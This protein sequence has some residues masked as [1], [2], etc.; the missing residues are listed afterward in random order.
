MPPLSPLSPSSQARRE[1]K[2]KAKHANTVYLLTMNKQ[3]TKEEIGDMKARKMTLTDLPVDLLEVIFKEEFRKLLKVSLRKWIYEQADRIDMKWLCANTSMHAI[4]I[5]KAKSRKN[6]DEL[7]W[8]RLSANPSAIDILSENEDRINWDEFSSNTSPDTITLFKRNMKKLNFA[9]LSGNPS[10]IYVLARNTYNVV[11][12]Y[13]GVKAAPIGITKNKDIDWMKVAKNPNGVELILT[14]KDD[15]EWDYWE[16]LCAN[17]S[18]KAIKLIEK[19]YEENPDNINF[20]SLSGNPTAI[21]LLKK[22]IK[23]ENGM[24]I[25]ELEDFDKQKLS[26]KNLSGNIGAIKILDERWKLEKSLKKTDYDTFRDWGLIVDWEILSGNIKAKKLLNAKY[27][28]EK[29][30]S[31]GELSR[32]ESN[33][34]L[35]WRALSGNPCAVDIIED[36]LIRAPNNPDIDWVALS[37]NPKAIH[38]LNKYQDKIVW[39]YLSTNP[40]IFG[41][42]GNDK[43]ATA[44]SSSSSSSSYKYVSPR[45]YL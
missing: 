14:N 12:S 10:A 35:D 41:I 32:L 34:K 11:E 1:E 4:E 38:I 28:E 27:E 33:E 24:S 9:K 25:D 44:H 36:E 39:E 22:Q 7:D 6:P 19:E 13:T 29:V 21:K 17:P 42:R 43:A 45:F 26:W 16:F 15:I 18:S 3:L 30:L 2:S 40:S 23:I 5:L 31:K 20:R 37:A 8:K